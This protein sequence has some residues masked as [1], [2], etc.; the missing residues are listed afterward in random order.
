[1]AMP[2][3]EK[4]KRVFYCYLCILYPSSHGEGRF[5][6]QVLRVIPGLGWCVRIFPTLCL[7][8]S[9]DLASLRTENKK[10]SYFL[11]SEI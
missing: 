4:E 11:K 9:P 10:R 1:M 2:C 6:A 8:S 5:A 3:G 7:Q